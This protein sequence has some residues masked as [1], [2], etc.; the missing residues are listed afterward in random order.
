[1]WVADYDSAAVTRFNLVSCSDPTC[2]EPTQTVCSESESL[3]DFDGDGS[4]DRAKL[5]ALVPL[6]HSDCGAR[7]LEAGW[8]FELT[9]ELGSTTFVASFGDCINPSDCKLL[10]G[11]D[12]DGD[13]RDEL[14][15]TLS[16]SSSSVWAIYRIT[17][18]GIHPLDLAA[19]GDPGFLEPGPI[20]LGGH[21]TSIMSSGFDC[22]V[23]DDGSRVLVAWSAERDDAVSPYRMHLTTLELDGD[24]FRV[25]GT[26]YQQDV[27]KLPPREGMCP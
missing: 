11:S 19:P 18:T 10:S 21:Q 26:D 23:E 13:G 5:L 22:R 17:E 8:Q 2:G 15:V 16:A 4:A 24:T 25:V 1:M 27:T 9:V 12:F 6:P 20:R 3:G 7:S 14:A